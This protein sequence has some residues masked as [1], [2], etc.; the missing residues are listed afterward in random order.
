MR[1]GWFI[2]GGIEETR[3]FGK[4]E[5]AIPVSGPKG[6]GTLYVGAVKEAGIWKLTL[7]QFSA[8][9]NIERLQLLK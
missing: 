3:G 1:F 5:L 7:L 4:A 9:D 6:K 2:A 8:N